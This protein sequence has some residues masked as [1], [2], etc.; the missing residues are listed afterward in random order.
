M[1]KSVILLA[2]FLLVFTN[3]NGQD[4]GYLNGTDMLCPTSEV[5]LTAAPAGYE[6]FYISHYGRHGARYAWQDDI[7]ET[8]N[9]MLAEAAKH[10]NLTPVGKQ[11]KEKFDILYPEV[12]Y[13]VGELSSVG[14]NQQKALAERAYSNF[15]SVWKGKAKVT[16]YTST[17]TRCVMTMSSFCLGLKGMN[18]KMEI[19]EHFGYKFLPAI[20]P[21]SSGNPFIDKNYRR[22]PLLF[23]ETWEQYIERKLD[24]KKI[25]DRL[26]VDAE[27]AVPADKNWH[28]VSYLY[29]LVNGMNSLE[30]APDLSFVFTRDER[31]A[32]WEIDNFQFY[33]QAWPTHLGYMPIV[34]DIIEKADTMIA[35]GKNGADLRFGHD[36]TLLPLLMILGVDGMDHACLNGDE[37]STWCRTDNVPMGANVQMVFYRSRK[38]K[39]ILFKVLLNGK[40]ATLPLET[41]KWPY[42]SW[43]SFKKHFGEE[44]AAN[45]NVTA[46]GPWVTNVTNG[47]ASILWT[48]STPGTGWVETSDGKRHYETYAGRRTSGTLHRVDICG[49]ETGSTLRYRIG[50]EPLL[51][52]ANPR[53]PKFGASWS[54]SWNEVALFDKGPSISFTVLNDIHSK[55]KEYKSLLNQ[56][57]VDSTNFIFLN[58][59]MAQTGNYDIERLSGTI[60]SPL[61]E[62][63]GNMPIMFARGN[64]EGRGTGI[65][66]VGAIFPNNDS[67]SFYYTFRQGP[68]AIAVFDAG[69]T[70]EERSVAFAGAPV[71]EDYLY[72]QIEWAKKVLFEKE[73]AEA[74]LKIC[75]IHV[76]MIDHR[77]KNDYKIQRW[78]NRNFLPLLNKAGID[79]MIGADLHEAMECLPGTMGNDFPIVVNE[80]V[81]RLE[82]KASDGTMTIKCFDTKGNRTYSNSFT[83]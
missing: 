73:F 69:E 19:F 38:S 78:L 23:D 80:D 47:S 1:K 34:K 31:V 52:D 48:T 62:L 75:I 83:Y 21:L 55:T 36:Y 22:V 43:D 37:I 14:W 44:I 33:A 26:F 41:G 50:G 81:K 64:H 79:I 17:S 16:A 77:I 46:V 68:A 4:D 63:A 12:R 24:Y 11:L 67:E 25:L 5:K 61:G 49:M 51:D 2:T 70:G 13:R 6:A 45:N 29:F 71:Y 39:D 65:R 28:I 27:K 56:I 40:E 8:F 35:S 9:E 30:N 3:L 42:Y 72:E 32:L 7:Y 60:I 59:D 74:P 53:K 20:L 18:P 66:N 76:P 82:F 57:D 54:G 10:D 58:G 15:P